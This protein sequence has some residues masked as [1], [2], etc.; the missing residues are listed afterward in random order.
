M[1][2]NPGN[3]CSMDNAAWNMETGILRLLRRLRMTALMKKE[4]RAL[5]FETPSQNVLGINLL[6]F[7][8][9]TIF[10]LR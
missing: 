2:S 1:N 8:F 10:T 5:S 4:K 6:I 7:F 3:S 9:Y